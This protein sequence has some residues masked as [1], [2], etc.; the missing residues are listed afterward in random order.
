MEWIKTA[1]I[2]KRI[3]VTTITIIINNICDGSGGGGGSYMY[4]S[5]DGGNN[6]R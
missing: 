5:Y 2:V 1:I 4:A 6:L 3:A